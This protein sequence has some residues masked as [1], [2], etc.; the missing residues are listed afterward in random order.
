MRCT[1][2]ILATRSG[3]DEAFLEVLK[4]PTAGDPMNELIKWTNLTYKEIA[5]GLKNAGFCVSFPLVGQLLKKHGYVKRKAQKN[6]Q[7]ELIKIVIL[8]LKILLD[9]IQNIEKRVIPL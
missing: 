3:I 2:S 6:R 1:Q 8:N 9:S 7:Q 5:V 4:F